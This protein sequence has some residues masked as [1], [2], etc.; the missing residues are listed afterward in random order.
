MGIP[1][2]RTT[3][4]PPGYVYSKENRLSFKKEEDAIKEKFPGLVFRSAIYS[5]LYLAFGTRSDILFIACKLEKAYSAPG[6]KDAE[7]LTS[8]FDISEGNE[9]LEYVFIQM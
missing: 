5:L 4:V 7:A 9:T 3:Q 6:M 2:H 8:Y 1:Q